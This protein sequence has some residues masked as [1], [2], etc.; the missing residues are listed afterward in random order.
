[1]SA[2]VSINLKLGKWLHSHDPATMRLARYLTTSAPPPPTLDLTVHVKQPFPMDDNDKL[3]DC[4]IAA[5]AHMVQVWSAMIGQETVVPTP[6][7]TAMYFKVT[8]GPDVGANENKVLKDWQA[9]PLAGWS[10]AAFVSCDP[11]DPDHIRRAA[12]LFGGVYIGIQLPK[13]AA[14]Q[15]NAHQDWDVTSPTDPLAQPG[16]WGGH[17]VNVV[18]YDDTHVT[19]VTWGALQRMTWN[20]WAAYCDEAWAVLPNDWEQ[21]PGIDWNALKGDLEEV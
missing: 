8:G 13:S 15:L 17:A 3:G 1:M 10:P 5:A 16:S 18:G 20:F 9:S 7:V 21:A 2:D 12:A 4:T 6:D 14:K 11:H 19:V